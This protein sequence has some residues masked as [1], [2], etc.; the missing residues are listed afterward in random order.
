M[1]EPILIKTRSKQLQT[2]TSVKDSVTEQE[3]EQEVEVEVMVQ[4]LKHFKC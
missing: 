3:K 1:E 2:I 4:G